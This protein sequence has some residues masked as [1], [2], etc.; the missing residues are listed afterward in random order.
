MCVRAGP[1]SRDVSKMIGEVNAI[2]EVYNK[3]WR[4]CITTTSL[5]PV[6]NYPSSEHDRGT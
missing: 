1:P 6:L 5:I 4:E 2:T 3:K